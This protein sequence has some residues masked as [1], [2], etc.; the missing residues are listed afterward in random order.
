[1]CPAIKV[2]R[3]DRGGEYLSGAF[4]RHLAAAASGTARRITVHDTPQLN[5][6]AGRLNRT[7][8]EKVPALLHTS[9]LPQN[10][11]GEALRHS[12]WLKNRTSTRA[13]GGAVWRTP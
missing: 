6:I 9:G 7:L 11:W 12:T 4:D 5:G 3:S 10:M 13:L 8:I 2:L 1:L